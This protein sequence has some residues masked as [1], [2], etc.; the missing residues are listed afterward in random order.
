M[1][2][3]TEQRIGEEV[4]WLHFII[5]GVVITS[6][7]YN[8]TTKLLTFPPRV[9]E[10]Q[11]P[12]TTL[13]KWLVELREFSRIL[14]KRIGPINHS[15]IGNFD[16]DWRIDKNEKTIKLN[17]TLSG[18]TNEAKWTGQDIKVKPREEIS[19]NPAQY[20]FFINLYE[21]LVD[22]IALVETS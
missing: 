11:I 1:S 10:L 21:Q 18:T 7:D 20:R 5:D 3:T 12:K 19:M 2:Y 4:S 6:V 8:P 17:F 14:D 9:T 22:N 13:I 15:P 16:I